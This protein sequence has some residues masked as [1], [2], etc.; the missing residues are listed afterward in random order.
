M[1]WKKE[2]SLSPEKAQPDLYQAEE[3][4]GHVLEAKSA[5][6][7]VLPDDRHFFYLAARRL[8]PPEQLHVELEAPAG[9]EGSHPIDVFLFKDLAATL[10]VPDP[11]AE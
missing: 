5:A 3:H 8:K 9:H 1:D 2:F 7:I 11:E 4:G 10:G 6:L